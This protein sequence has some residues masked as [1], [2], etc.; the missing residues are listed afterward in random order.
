MSLIGEDFDGLLEQLCS[1]PSEFSRARIVNQDGI[2]VAFDDILRMFR[3][4]DA[5]ESCDSLN[6][7]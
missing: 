1:I 5:G 4:E 6:Y 7:K 3:R 2:P